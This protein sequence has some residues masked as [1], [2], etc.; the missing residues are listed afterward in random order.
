MA[1]IIT[2]L[3]GE[4][5]QNILNGSYSVE[6]SV[7]GYNNS[8]I[9]PSTVNVVEGTNNYAFTISANGTLTLHVSDDGT[10][11]GNPIVGAIFVRTDSSGTEY[12]DPIT[13]NSEG[14]AIFENVPYAQDDAPTIYFK[15]TASD[16]EHEFNNQVQSITMNSDAQTQEIQNSV[17][18]LRTFTLTDANYENLPIDNGTITLN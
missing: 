15:Q 11:T 12:G 18:A 17:P 14:N 9:S 13:S 5:S 4:G 1:K 6:A 2:I 3:N 10:S 16:S 8:S 7:D